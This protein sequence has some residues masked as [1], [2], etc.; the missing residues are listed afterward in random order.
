MLPKNTELLLINNERQRIQEQMTREKIKSMFKI[1]EKGTFNFRNR[2]GVIREINSIKP[3]D[4]HPEFHHSTFKSTKRYDA[5]S[6]FKGDKLNIF[7]GN[8]DELDAKLRQLERESQLMIQTRSLS[9]PRESRT[10]DIYR[11]ANL[12]TNFNYL[13]WQL[14]TKETRKDIVTQSRELLFK[15]I[16]IRNKNEETDKLREFIDWEN[17]K[18]VEAKNSFKEDGDKFQKYVEDLTLKAEQAKL[19]TEALIEVKQQKTKMISNLR[20]TKADVEREISKINVEL[21]SALIH[22]NFI[23]ELAKEQST[24]VTKSKENGKKNNKHISD[25]DLEFF[26]TTAYEFHIIFYWK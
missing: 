5:I 13:K 19:E 23:L 20:E 6:P 14:E 25:S 21:A 3:I 4:E 17:E 8:P 18:L 11:G 26:I 16:S 22:K 10:I 1:H 7:D 15:E 9:Q 12:T 2:E 24:T